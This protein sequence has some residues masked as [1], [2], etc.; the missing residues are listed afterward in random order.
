MC[1]NPIKEK[2]KEFAE[3]YHI[4][5]IMADYYAVVMTTNKLERA[6]SAYRNYTTLI[7]ICNIWDSNITKTA[8]ML[9]DMRAAIKKL[10]LEK[11][12]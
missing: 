4:C 3:K 5:A 11:E 8:K 1:E 7:D 9:S 10:T 2:M 12:V 6:L